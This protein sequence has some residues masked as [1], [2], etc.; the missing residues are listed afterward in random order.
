M[1]GTQPLA[2]E[3]TPHVEANLTQRLQSGTAPIRS[4]PNWKLLGIAAAV[5]VVVIGALIAFKG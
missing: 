2:T 1:N 3:G 4:A 5:L